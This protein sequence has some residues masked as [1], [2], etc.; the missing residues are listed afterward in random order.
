LVTDRV[1]TFERN[2]ERLE[3]RRGETDSALQLKVTRNDTPHVYEFGD[4]LSLLRFQSDME[5]MLVQTGWTFVEFTPD[6]RSG[7]DRR[8]WPRLPDDRRRWWTDGLRDTAAVST[9]KSGRSR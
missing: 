8:G 4:A 1:W 2:G 6:R 5:S 7:R 9:S 3:I